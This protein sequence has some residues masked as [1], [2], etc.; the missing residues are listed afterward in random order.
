MPRPTI[1]R[2]RRLALIGVA[3]LALS[4]GVVPSA[5]VR[6]VEPPVADPTPAPTATPAPIPVGT[7]DEQI[8]R[9]AASPLT[10]YGPDG[11]A[12]EIDPSTIAAWLSVVPAGGSAPPTVTPPTVTPPPDPLASAAPDPLA[13]PSPSPSLDPL[14]TPTPMPMPTPTTLPE[15]GAARVAIDRQSIVVWL[16]DLLPRYA[17]A[18]RNATWKMNTA[19]KFVSVVPSKDGRG[20]DRSSS[21]RSIMDALLRRAAMDT[22]SDMATLVVGPARPPITTEKATAMMPK[23]RKISGWTTY[24]Q[25]GENNGFGANIIIPAKKINGTVILPGAIFDFWKVV[26]T[27]TV[28]EGY[29]AGG[30]IIN[31][32]SQPT[33]AFAGG[34][35]STST[36]IFNAALR[37]GFE[38]L[39]RVPHYYYI[40]R[41]PLGLDATVWMD[42]G[43]IQ[44]V[45]WRNDSANPV[46]IRS[47]A[48]PGIVTFELYS[49]PVGRTVAFSTPKVSG[50]V[51]AADY[52]EYTSS[53]PA[54]AAQRVEFPHP[55]MYVEVVRTVKDRAGVVLH[56]E[57][58]KSHYNEVDGRTLVGKSSAPPTVTPTPLPG[59]GGHPAGGGPRPS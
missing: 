21:A 34:I 38:I 55:G 47:V 12:T 32:K 11:Y 14:A 53:L 37:A 59:A 45:I 10:V 51:G 13:S 6:A 52:T 8:A 44:S 57:T 16:T 3:C 5:V 24:W 49:L 29:K 7:A 36:T 42:G 18:G 15:S 56:R 19:G 17:V 20:L 33:G 50:Q 48:K 30:A 23:M 46:Y 35:C 41:Y 1:R 27:P 25:V 26:G 4:G 54:G 22:S 40:D 28:A 43:S 39:S 58:W 9:M 31:G 2:R